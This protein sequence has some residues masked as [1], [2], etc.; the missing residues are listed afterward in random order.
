MSVQC[1]TLHIKGY[2][3]TPRFEVTVIDVELPAYTRTWS[4]FT[5]AVRIAELEYTLKSEDGER[6]PSIADFALYLISIAANEPKTQEQ[7]G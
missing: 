2:L 1:E 3:R 6:K 4:S 7:D 5:E